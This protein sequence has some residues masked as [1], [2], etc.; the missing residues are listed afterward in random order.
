MHS[1]Q[2]QINDLKTKLARAQEAGAESEAHKNA[3][4][5]ESTAQVRVN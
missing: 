1:G 3:Q 2:P 5:A 4:I